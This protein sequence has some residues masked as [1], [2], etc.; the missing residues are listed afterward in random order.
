[1][2]PAPALY[3]SPADANV[4]HYDL[5]LLYHNGRGHSLDKGAVHGDRRYNRKR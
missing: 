4:P 5:D 3:A 1:M 2:L